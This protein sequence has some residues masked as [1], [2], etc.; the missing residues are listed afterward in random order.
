MAQKLGTN[1]PICAQFL[2]HKFSTN[3]SQ[4]WF[5]THVTPSKPPFCCFQHMLLPC[6]CLQHLPLPPLQRAQMVSSVR[7]Y[8]GNVW[9]HQNNESSMNNAVCFCNSFSTT[10]TGTMSN[11]NAKSSYKHIQWG[12]QW[13]DDSNEKE[14][15]VMR[16]WWQNEE[17][18]KEVRKKRC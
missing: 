12:R 16:W 6:C 9:P 4:I 18:N 13:H 2:W 15:L 7:K 1:F 17:D 8:V 5:L 10:V 14:T 3:I 11:D